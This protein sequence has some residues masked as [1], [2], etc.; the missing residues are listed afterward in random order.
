MGCRQR[1]LD[2]TPAIRLEKELQVFNLA[3]DIT[4]QIHILN[5]NPGIV[6]FQELCLRMNISFFFDRFLRGF[7][8]MMRGEQQTI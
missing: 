5:A 7:K 6:S 8:G 4:A 1:L 2:Q 3:L